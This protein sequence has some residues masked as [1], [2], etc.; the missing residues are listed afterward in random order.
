VDA[1]CQ[2]RGH[3]CAL[4]PLLLRHAT[5]G[6]ALSQVGSQ[7]SRRARTHTADH[8]LNNCWFIARRLHSWLH[9]TFSLLSP[10]A[11]DCFIQRVRKI[12]SRRPNLFVCFLST[13]MIKKYI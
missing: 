4:H 10:R 7:V 6:T 1:G 9:V 5:A 12:I 2:S 13:N 11:V 8:R 3:E